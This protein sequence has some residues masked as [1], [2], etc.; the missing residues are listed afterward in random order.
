MLPA[1]NELP[2]ITIQNVE[3]DESAQTISVTY[4]LSDTEGDEIEVFLRV[5]DDEGNSYNVPTSAATGNIGFPVVPGTNKQI[6]WEYG[7]QITATGDYR[8]KLVADDRFVISP[9]ELVAQV[10]SQRLRDWLVYIDGPRHYVT[11]V[12]QLNR[13]RDTLEQAFLSNGLETYRQQ[14]PYASITGENIIGTQAG[15][16]EAEQVIIIGGHYDTVS[17]APGADDNGSAVVGVL[18]AAHILSQYRLRKSLRFVGFDLE[19]V[20]L[21]G[22]NYLVNHLS[23]EEE[24]TGMINLEMIGYYSDLPNTQILP[25]GF[26]LLFPEAS[27]AVAADDFRGN[28]I[29]NVGVTDFDNLSTAFADAAAT[30]VPDLRVIDLI[31][32]SGMIPPDLLRSDHA[33]FWLN[34]LPALMI[35]DG[36]EFRNPHYH[37][38]SDTVGT[39]NFTFMRQVVQAVIASVADLGGLQHSSEAIATFQISTDTEEYHRLACDLS[40]SPLPARSE[41]RLAFGTCTVASLQ[42]EL[43]DHHGRSLLTRKADPMRGDI[44][45]P[46]ANLPAGVYWLRLSDGHHYRMHRVV[47]Q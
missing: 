37:E 11:G 40:I 7:G 12:E 14:F 36:A 4:D 35:T 41:L 30:Y 24:L 21:R 25:A 34:D 43:L 8:L 5:S 42:L 1:Q 46:V 13:C 18:E 2:V 20:G 31:S 17:D 44:I 22:S 39:L 45:L 16:V 29:T 19:E 3:L 26:E 10:D 38:P 9:E 47:V 32:P 33:P 23:A 6:T 15:T 27:A 28:F